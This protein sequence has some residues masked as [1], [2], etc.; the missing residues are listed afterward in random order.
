MPLQPDEKTMSKLRELYPDMSDDE[1][2]EIDFNITQY[3]E[4]AWE[5]YEESI[6]SR[7]PGYSKKSEY[8]PHNHQ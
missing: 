4:L 2:R 1:L 7:K 6:L 5:I 8:D 3:I